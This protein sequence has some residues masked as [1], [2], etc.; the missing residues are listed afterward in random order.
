MTIAHK[1]NF[2]LMFTYT[3]CIFIKGFLKNPPQKPGTKILLYLT[4]LSKNINELLLPIADKITVGKNSLYVV[5]FFNVIKRL[6][7]AL[8]KL[9]I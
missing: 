7:I 6:R 1:G 2:I 3:T 8:V 4:N 9:C 5:F